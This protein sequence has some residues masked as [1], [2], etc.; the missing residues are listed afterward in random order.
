MWETGKIIHPHFGLLKVEQTVIKRLSSLVT[1]FIN[2]NEKGHG[3]L[4]TV[5]ILKTYL[6]N[7]VERNDY[8]S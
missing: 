2:D 3:V 4:N 8:F 5:G 7:Q 6:I 1:D